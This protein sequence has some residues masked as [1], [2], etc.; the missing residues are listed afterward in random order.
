[1]VFFKGEAPSRMTIFHWK[2]HIQESMAAP[3]ILD[4]LKRKEKHKSG[5]EAG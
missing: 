1:M 2:P 4:G 5:M 3:N